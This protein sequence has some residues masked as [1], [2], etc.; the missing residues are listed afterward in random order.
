MR[1]KG[2]FIMCFFVNNGLKAQRLDI[3][4]NLGRFYSIYKFTD[5]GTGFR[6]PSSSQYSFFPSV[7]FNKKYSRLVSAEMKASF[8]V[9]QQ[10][11]STR[12]Y[13]PNFYSIMNGGNFSLTMNYSLIQTDKIECRLKA[14]LGLG[15]IPDM[16]KAEFVE[17]YYLD[18]LYDSISRGE[19]KRDFTPLF[20]TISTGLDFSYKIAKRIKLLIA[21][22]YQK[23]FLRITEYDIY[24]N[25][26][27][28]NNDQRAKQWG[29][30]DFYGVQLGIRYALRDENGNKYV[31]KKNK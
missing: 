20:P 22:N 9:N 15:L 12:L 16:Y 17:L 6:N 28:G 3:G 10:Y 1:L 31:N 2:L 25:D 24:Y 27:S 18:P 29:T 14:G 8:I 4:I 26:G 19:I 11:I 23:G 30:G 13:G 7:V 5:Y 21:A